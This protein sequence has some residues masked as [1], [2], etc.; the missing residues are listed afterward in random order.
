MNKNSVDCRATAGKL[1][2]L[3]RLREWFWENNP[4]EENT[5]LLLCYEMSRFAFIVD[6]NIP[7]RI[8]KP[9]THFVVTS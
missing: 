8:V 6:Q 4:D 2:K 5:L 7:T 9:I 3:V 1:I